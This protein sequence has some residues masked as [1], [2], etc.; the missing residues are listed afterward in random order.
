MP[1]SD[2]ATYVEH[3]WWPLGPPRWQD[4][5]VSDNAMSNL[6]CNC[7]SGWSGI[8]PA[9]PCPYH[10][11]PIQAHNG[12]CHCRGPFDPHPFHADAYTTRA[13][14]PVDTYKGK[15]RAD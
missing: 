4:A 11:P 12:L 1:T 7:N 2:N 6:V 9:P 10:W 5:Q 8:T 15:H 3:A 14:Q 13:F